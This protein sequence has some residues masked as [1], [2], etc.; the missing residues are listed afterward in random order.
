MKIRKLIN[1]Y[2]C[3]RIN[4][5]VKSI[6][7]EW[8]T[9]S[10]FESLHQAGIFD[11]FW[12]TLLDRLS[13]ILKVIN[14]Q[15]VLTFALSCQVLV[16]RNGFRFRFRGSFGFRIWFGTCSWRWRQV[17]AVVGIAIIVVDFI[18]TRRIVVR[19]WLPVAPRFVRFWTG[20]RL[21]GSSGSGRV[22]RNG[23]L[24]DRLFRHARQLPPSQPFFIKRL[25]SLT[26]KPEKIKL[27]LKN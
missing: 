19:G 27:N 8:E 17:F 14:G 21:A 7:S 3:V 11:G 15:R 6:L 16:V 23:S 2:N 12:I 10:Q 9:W 5:W 18:A 25:R 20:R 1:E 4:Y 24:P 13:K 26:L 22:F